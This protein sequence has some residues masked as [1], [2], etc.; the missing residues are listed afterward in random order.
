M[1]RKCSTFFDGKSCRS[2]YPDSKYDGKCFSFPSNDIDK[3]IW[4]NSLPNYINTKD[5]TKWMGICERHWK[6]GYETKTVQGGVKR[7]VHAPNEFGSTPHSDKRQSAVS[8]TRNTESRGVLS[9]ER[10][11]V[12]ENLE[13]ER[14]KINSWELLTEHCDTLN[15][16]VVGNENFVTLHFWSK[17]KD[18]GFLPGYGFDII[19]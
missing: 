9:N 16:M 12:A 18:I 13:K 19:V 7:P 1:G 5:V 17:N 3:E 8:K 4:V 15:L 10:A 2:G 11:M 6:P 14:D